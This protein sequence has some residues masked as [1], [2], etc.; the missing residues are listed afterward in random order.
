[1]TDVC[2]EPH[3]DH[4]DILCDKAMPCLG[5]HENIPAALTWDG[6]PLPEKQTAET[7]SKRMTQIASAATPQKM[8][9]PPVAARITDPPSSHKAAE[10]IEVRSGSHRERLLV[11]YVQ[12]SSPLSDVQASRAAKMPD[13]SCWWKRCSELRQG[14]FIEVVGEA[15]DPETGA[16][17]Q[18]CQATD[19]GRSHPVGSR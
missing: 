4:P 3:P 7:K 6:L 16:M 14:G 12:S 10:Q 9:G 5:Y 11:A 19:L 1:M 17:V 13:R 15:L 2:N 18:V 8:V